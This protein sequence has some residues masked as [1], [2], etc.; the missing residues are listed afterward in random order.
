MHLTVVAV[1]KLGRGPVAEAVRALEARARHY[2]PLDVREIRQEAAASLSKEALRAREWER[3]RGAI[4]AGSPLVVCDERGASM[5]SLAFARW[6][7]EAL[8]GGR[9]VTFVIGGA[10]GLPEEARAAASTLLALAPWTL[11]HDL[12]RLVL[13]EQLYRAGTIR[14]GEPY[15]KS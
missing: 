9:D 11:S 3:I 8:E 10:Y 5:T 2:W 1:G 14:R 12:A 13:A 6:L 15:H 4:A 7:G